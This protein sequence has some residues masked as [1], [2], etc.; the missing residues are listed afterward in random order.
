M[1]C[2]RVREELGLPVYCDTDTRAG[3][4]ATV[5]VDL[6]YREAWRASLV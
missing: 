4:L 5:P 6:G 2:G 3:H 1:F